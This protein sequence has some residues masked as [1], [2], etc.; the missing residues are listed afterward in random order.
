MTAWSIYTF[1][2]NRLL[3]FL[4]R[5]WHGY[6]LWVLSLLNK[7]S[8]GLFWLFCLNKFSIFF[9]DKRLLWHVVYFKFGGNLLISSHFPKCYCSLLLFIVLYK[10]QFRYIFTLFVFLRSTVCLYRL[11]T[12][13]CW[14]D[15]A[16]SSSFVT[17]TSEFPKF[18]NKNQ[19]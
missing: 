17:P 19:N 5:S 15:F 2:R 13:L 3:E 10:A 16:S 4:E 18:I 8:V 11:S 12:I 6:L 9:R 14:L 7:I 1:F